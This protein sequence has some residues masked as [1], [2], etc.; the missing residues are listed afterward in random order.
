MMRNKS[1]FWPLRLACFKY[2][3]YTLYH[4]DYTK[5]RPARQENKKIMA[6][7]LSTRTQKCSR[8]AAILNLERR[9]GN[10]KN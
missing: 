1:T 3:P 7:F 5:N 9:W 2:P 4:I 8:T 10:E 6:S